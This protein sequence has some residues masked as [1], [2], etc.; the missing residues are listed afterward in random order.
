MPP[1]DEKDDKMTHLSLH[2]PTFKVIHHH[3]ARQTQ[4]AHVCTLLQETVDG[5]IRDSQSLGL[6]DGLDFF[7]DRSAEREGERRRLE[8]WVGAESRD[9]GEGVPAAVPGVSIGVT[10]D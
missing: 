5:A 3:A 4:A 10:R 9:C 6:R 7:H 2:R 8:E 1:R